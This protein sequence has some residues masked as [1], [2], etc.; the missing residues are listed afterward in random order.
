MDIYK[1]MSTDLDGIGW[2]QVG[3]QLRTFSNIKGEIE[4]LIGEGKY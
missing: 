2:E 3:V 4:E 1:N